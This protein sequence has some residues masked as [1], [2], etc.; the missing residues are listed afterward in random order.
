MSECLA[1]NF[2]SYLSLRHIITGIVH[3]HV[4][5]SFW[6]FTSDTVFINCFFQIK[7][8]LVDIFLNVVLNEIIRIRCCISEQ[9]L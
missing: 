5:H 4:Y 3:N 1:F 2:L 8:L 9:F 6:N 7:D